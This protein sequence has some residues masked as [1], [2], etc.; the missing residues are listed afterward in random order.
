MNTP[1][2]T[3]V[4][5][6]VEFF[7]YNC[8]TRSLLQIKTRWRD[9]ITSSE[10]VCEFG[11]YIPVGLG[12]DCVEVFGCLSALVGKTMYRRSKG[13]HGYPSVACGIWGTEMSLRRLRNLEDI[14]VS[15]QSRGLKNKMKEA[16]GLYER[17]NKLVELG[18]AFLK[19][20]PD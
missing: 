9:E 10:E 7:C 1:E 4:S 3:D 11:S 18:D 16:F 20:V 5:V 17:A 2:M 19:R 8:I 6:K 14:I 13:C 15:P 12:Q